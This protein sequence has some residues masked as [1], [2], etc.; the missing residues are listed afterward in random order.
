MF[1]STFDVACGEVGRRSKL[2]D[3]VAG[4]IEAAPSQLLFIGDNQGV[5]DG[6]HAG[7]L[8]GAPLREQ[9]LARRA[10]PHPLTWY[11]RV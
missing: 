9:L 4:A 5:L 7:S 3:E 10:S 8:A 1:D 11:A 2:H 6:E